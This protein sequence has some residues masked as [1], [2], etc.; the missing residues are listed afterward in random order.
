M[1]PTFDL[2]IK[3]NVSAEVVNMVNSL[4]AESRN[5]SRQNSIPVNSRNS[6]NDLNLNNQ[7]LLT[8]MQ[9]VFNAG[10]NG[11]SKNFND[12]FDDLIARS[13]RPPSELT[14]IIVAYSILSIVALFGNLLVCH[15]IVKN[16]RLHTVTHLF[17]ANMA[18]SDLLLTCVNYP[19]MLARR[20]TDQ[21]LYGAAACHIVHA[22][23][24]TSVYVSTFTMTAI[25]VD[26]YFVILYPLRPRL[27]PRGGSVVVLVTWTLGVLCSLPV[28]L[29]ARVEDVEFFFE[30]STRCRVVY[31]E[32]AVMVERG[33]TLGTFVAQYVV[34]MALTA[35]AYGQI[36]RFMW[37]ERLTVGQPSEVQQKSHDRTRRK[38]VKMLI[39]VVAV[40]SACWLPLNMYHLLTD[41]HPGGA[42]SSAAYLACHWLATS[43]ACYNPF[44]YCWLNESFQNELRNL[45][46]CTRHR[47]PRVHP[48]LALDDGRL[49][50]CDL[51]SV[52]A[53]QGTS[54]RSMLSV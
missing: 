23:L 33:V 21:W 15:V 54:Q 42:H 5:M 2:P 52:L 26:R 19:V 37:F 11:S 43:S 30:T 6:L 16:P 17:I 28:A 8:L 35:F 1:S 22:T 18:V 36:V 49:V 10:G 45:F 4:L 44:I 7:Q 12:S 39:V 27:A 20:V 13:R 50:R 34:P 47:Q 48:A 31:P 32:P 24:Q 25:A 38:T 53:L 3:R 51:L 14:A 9:T 29:F 46:A 41:L 40:F